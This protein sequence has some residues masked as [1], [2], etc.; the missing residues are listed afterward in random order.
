MSVELL[1]TTAFENALSC[2][3]GERR[4][5]AQIFWRDWADYLFFD[6][7]ILFEAG[8][9]QA[10]N[11]LL[12]QDDSYVIAMINLGNGSTEIQ[13]E[14]RAIYLERNTTPKEYIS[15][16]MGD[17]SPT[18][19]LFLMDRYVLASEKGHWSIYCEKENDVAV[20]AVDVCVSEFTCSQLAKTL[21]AK[22]IA[23]ALFPSRDKLFDFHKLTP[24][25][26]S[27]LTAEYKP[28]HHL[29]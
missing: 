16:L 17:G 23:A 9:I 13:A 26:K 6:P 11:L 5:P 4:F 3:R 20:L 15:E 2:I 7:S 14:V 1:K 10:K 29:V 21:D 8:F 25:W 18:N 22:S 12:R 28:F 27:A 19:W 24:E